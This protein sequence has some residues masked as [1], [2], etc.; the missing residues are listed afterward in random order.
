MGNSFL[1]L[2]HFPGTMGKRSICAYLH[3]VWRQMPFGVQTLYSTWS[4]V[5]VRYL[6]M[7]E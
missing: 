6:V 5:H 7:V 4:L 1:V 3:S 2:N